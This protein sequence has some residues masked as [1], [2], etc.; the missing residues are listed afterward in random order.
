MDE[1]IKF[2]EKYKKMGYEIEDD[3]GVII[4]Y[5]DAYD[6]KH[7]SDIRK[8]INESKYD[9]SWGIRPRKGTV[10]ENASSIDEENVANDDES[11]SKI[12]PFEREEYSINDDLEEKMAKMPLNEKEEINEEKENKEIV[13]NDEPQEESMIFT[14]ESLFD[15][16]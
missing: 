16:F 11:V 13:L 12:M 8:I 3:N 10:K 6:R 1:K 14:Q 15:L 7:I 4:F 9:C 2:I 5:I